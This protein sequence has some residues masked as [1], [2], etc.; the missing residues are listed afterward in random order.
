MS[1]LN[2]RCSYSGKGW[3]GRVKNATPAAGGNQGTVLEADREA[4]TITGLRERKTS[5]SRIRKIESSM[6]RQPYDLTFALTAKARC[7][8]DETKVRA[9]KGLFFIC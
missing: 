6:G 7:K 8:L 3:T 5:V 2:S 4:L 1:R 9:R